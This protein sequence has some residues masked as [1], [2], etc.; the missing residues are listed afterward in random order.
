M[1]DNCKGTS[2][3]FSFCINIFVFSFLFFDVAESRMFWGGQK[4]SLTAEMATPTIYRLW[5][6]E[7][8]NQMAMRIFRSYPSHRPSPL[9]NA[10]ASKKNAPVFRPNLN[11]IFKTGFLSP[12]QNMVTKHSDKRVE[13]NIRYGNKEE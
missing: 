2:K 4:A 11:E 5:P 13:D 1:K 3:L 12:K 7:G 10:F 9:E 6:H 8:Q